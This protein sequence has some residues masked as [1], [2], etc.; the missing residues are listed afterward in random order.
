MK[1]NNI[2]GLLLIII[3]FFAIINSEFV[4]TGAFISINET[5][6]LLSIAGFIAVFLGVLLFI[7]SNDNKDD[8]NLEKKIKKIKLTSHIRD[9]GLVGYAKK[10]TKD[11]YV[12]VEMNHLIQELI[13][14]NYDAGKGEVGHIANTDIHYM[15]G[16]NGARLFYRKVGEDKENIDYDIVGKSSKANEDAVRNKLEKL[17]QGKG[18]YKQENYKAEKIKKKKPKKT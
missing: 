3:G 18:L 12:Q 10:A 7:T 4:L 14:G 1:Y 6:D 15:R 16:E 8:G 13:K 9:S 11:Q 17:Y 5:T 2:F